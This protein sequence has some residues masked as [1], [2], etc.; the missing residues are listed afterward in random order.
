M[1]VDGGCHCGHIQYEAE[2][3]AD[4]VIICHCTDCQTLSGSAFRVVVQTAPGKFWLLTGE[5]KIYTKVADSGAAREQAFCPECGTAI[6]SRPVGEQTT[7]LGLRVGTISQRNELIPRDQYW[8]R[9]SQSWLAGL[10]T[11]HAWKTQPA[12]RA[13]GAFDE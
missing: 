1:K 4:R 11:I 7:A 10:G 3:E 5:P 13:D 2:I 12:F 9:S 8:S 6:F